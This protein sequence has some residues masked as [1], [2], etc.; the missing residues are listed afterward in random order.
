MRILSLILFYFV[1]VFPAYADN[2]IQ[3][4]KIYTCFQ[5]KSVVEKQACERVTHQFEFD[6]DQNGL[7]DRFLGVAC[8]NAGCR[9]H[10]FIQNSK[11][12]YEYKGSISLH[13]LSFETLAS[14]HNGLPDILDYWRLNAERGI[15]SRNQFDGQKYIKTERYEGDSS[16][17]K[18]IQNPEQIILSQ[19][20]ISTIEQKNKDEWSVYAKFEG[21]GSKNLL[22]AEHGIKIRNY[23]KIDHRLYL[24][25]YS[26]GHA[27]TEDGEFGYSFGLSKDSEG[28]QR[29]DAQ[30]I[31]KHGKSPDVITAFD[32]KNRD[33]S[34]LNQLGPKLNNT[35]WGP[36]RTI[37]YRQYLMTIK[38]LD[39]K[40]I[41]LGE[42]NIP[43]FSRITF[44]I[45]IK[46]TDR[47]I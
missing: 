21:P 18:L 47:S 20:F 33:N 25:I 38:V 35:T 13:H 32:F 10:I 28:K 5:L 24:Q 12:G 8:G 36:S 4:N 43:T 39:A 17:F 6:L 15:L 14:I 11:E 30:N 29:I 27:G 42:N 19:E 45:V 22:H 46:K 41:N 34:G 7:V 16:L 3:W 37:E 44:F 40:I 26:L 1:I 23:Q 9:Y 2:Q 31:P